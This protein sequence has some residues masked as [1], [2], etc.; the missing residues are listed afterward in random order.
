MLGHQEGRQLKPV[1]VNL[2][3]VTGQD[4]VMDK[5]SIGLKVHIHTMESLSSAICIRSGE[6][7]V[8]RGILKL[9]VE[10]L[11]PVA[12]ESVIRQ[13]CLSTAVQTRPCA[14]E[15]PYHSPGLQPLQPKAW[16]LSFL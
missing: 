7:E 3:G 10:R 16:P 12:N 2:A 8:G 13:F 4:E 1:R 6:T 15:G 11:N 5:I 14:R 9:K